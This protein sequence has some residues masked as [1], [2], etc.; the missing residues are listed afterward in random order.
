MS[1]PPSSCNS[2]QKPW[3]LRYEGHGRPL[4]CRMRC[5][6]RSGRSSCFWFI[7]FVYLCADKMRSVVARE[8]GMRC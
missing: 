1:N 8:R 6:G 7:L 2:R 5:S 3:L 4:A